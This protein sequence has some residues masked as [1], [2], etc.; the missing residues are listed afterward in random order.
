MD[1]KD[2]QS[3]L[4]NFQQ[5]YLQFSVNFFFYKIQADTLLFLNDY[6]GCFS[7][8]NLDFRW[9]R[10]NPNRRAD[11]DFYKVLKMDPKDPIASRDEG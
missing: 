8:Q 1:Q 5:K 6:N 9:H 7:S 4:W 3:I 2:L 11:R 10:A